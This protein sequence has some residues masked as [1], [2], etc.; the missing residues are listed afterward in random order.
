MNTLTHINSLIPCP[1]Q[2]LCPS[3]SPHRPTQSPSFHMHINASEVTL[4]LYLQSETLWFLPPFDSSFLSPKTPGLP[5]PFVLAS[6]KTV[7][8]PSRLG[9][10]AGLFTCDDYPV[11]V[12]KSHVM[13]EAFLHLHARDSGKISGSYTLAM[14]AYVELYIDRDGFLNVDLLPEPLRTFYVE[15]QRAPRPIHQ[16]T[17]KLK[18]ALGYPDLS[19][20][21][22]NW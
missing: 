9:R 4:D 5:A 15:F 19:E 10:G 12:P 2:A 3:N 11:I 13:L 6:D 20:D 1:D 7:L 22:R 17:M 18:T 8:P 16:W 21:D 14:I